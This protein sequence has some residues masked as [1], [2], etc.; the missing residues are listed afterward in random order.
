MAAPP[1]PVGGAGGSGCGAA[2]GGGGSGSAVGAPPVD[3]PAAAGAA[4]DAGCN[5]PPTTWLSTP[6]IAP[7]TTVHS[8]ADVGVIPVMPAC[9]A[10]SR[11]PIPVTTPPTTAS[12]PWPRP[13]VRI[14]PRPVTTPS[15]TIPSDTSPA[16]VSRGDRPVTLTQPWTVQTSVVA[17]I[18]YRPDPNRAYSATGSDPPQ[19]SIAA[20]DSCVIV[21]L[22]GQTLTAMSA[23]VTGTLEAPRMATTAS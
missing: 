20:A 4:P 17:V 1:A 3:G 12:G 15:R 10:S 19:W 14:A 9:W 18:S 13:P 23:R 8:T 2:G 6:L 21:Q 16:A 22:T 5:R 7:G 11:R